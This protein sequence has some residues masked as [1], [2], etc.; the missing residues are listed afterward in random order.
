MAESA[1]EEQLK[2]TE[3]KIDEEMINVV[4]CRLLK[5]I[6]SLKIFLRKRKQH[7]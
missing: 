5:F 2:R 3:K 7:C 1:F 6:Y 4:S